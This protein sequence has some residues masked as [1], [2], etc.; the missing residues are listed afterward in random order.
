MLQSTH[1]MVHCLQSILPSHHFQAYAWQGALAKQV[2][3][4]VLEHVERLY[5]AAASCAYKRAAR[6]RASRMRS[7]LWSLNMRLET[8]MPCSQKHGQVAV[9]AL[10]RQGLQCHVRTH[11]SSTHAHK[12]KLSRITALKGPY[13]V[14]ASK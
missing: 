3:G 4:G 7:M 9:N 2:L 12:I 13:K 1:V 8:R 6:W 10:A 11:S 5:A 14:R